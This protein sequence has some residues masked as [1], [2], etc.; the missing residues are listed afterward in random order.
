MFFGSTDA[1]SLRL[2]GEVL[3]SPPPY[4]TLAHIQNILPLSL[5]LPSR[6]SITLT[7]DIPVELDRWKEELIAQSLSL[8]LLFSPRINSSFLP[9]FLLRLIAIEKLV[10][11]RNPHLTV[12]RRSGGGGSAVSD[13]ATSD[14]CSVWKSAPSS[15]VEMAEME[16]GCPTALYCSHG[17]GKLP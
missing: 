16:A 3:S 17:R 13:G 2:K 4:L 15:S 1:I 6:S 5:F 10:K 7:T 8:S 14:V 12:R 11:T 9:S